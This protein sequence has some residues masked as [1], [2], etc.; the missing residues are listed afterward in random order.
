MPDQPWDEW[1]V[2]LFDSEFCAECGGDAEHHEPWIFMGNWFAHCIYP[3][4]DDDSG[5]WHPVIADFRRNYDEGG[6][7]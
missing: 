2:E 4:G 7:R 5:T 6:E 1:V 3:P